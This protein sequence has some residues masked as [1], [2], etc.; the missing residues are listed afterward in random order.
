MEAGPSQRQ[1]L[2]LSKVGEIEVTNPIII[3][4]V[5]VITG[6]F[7]WEAVQLRL[8]TLWWSG[9]GAEI[10]RALLHCTAGDALIAVAALAVAVLVARF[11]G[12]PLF[13]RRMVVTTILL[14][15]A[16][17]I[18][19]EWLNVEIRRSWAYTENMPI[20]P[21]LGV[22][23]APMLQWLVAPCIAFAVARR[24]QGGNHR[25]GRTHHPGINPRRDASPSLYM[26]SPSG[27][28]ESEPYG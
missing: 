4:F 15:I 5:T 17:T 16:Y 9:T 6:D 21:F 24:F 3:Y 26:A 13:G 22:G 8:Y 14:G 2:Y 19:S 27:E 1:G 12:W 28:R 23:L 20:L 25:E 10:L 11:A 7:V 18:F